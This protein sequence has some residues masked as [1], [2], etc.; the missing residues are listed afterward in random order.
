MEQ[1]SSSGPSL[2]SG[3]PAALHMAYLQGRVGQSEQW[4]QQREGQPPPPA[5]EHHYSP[6]HCSVSRS[7]EDGKPH[8]RKSTEPRMTAGQHSLS[9]P[10]TLVTELETHVQYVKLLTVQGC[11]LSSE[12]SCHENWPPLCVGLVYLALFSN[13]PALLS[14]KRCFLLPPGN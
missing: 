3:P 8:N 10:G 4:L 5:P 14:L 6:C 1:S 11:V 13:P 2:L 7:M 9:H 12:P